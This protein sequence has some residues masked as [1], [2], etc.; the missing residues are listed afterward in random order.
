MA[1]LFPGFEYDIFISYRQK[2]NKHDGWVTGFVD[3]LK[4]ELESTFKEEISVY[5]DINPHDGLLETHDVDASLKEKLKCIIFIPV[6]SRTYCDPKAFAWEHEFLA[7]IEQASKDRFGLKIK[8]PNG[9][10][11]SRVLPVRIHDLDSADIRLCESALGGVI[12]GVDFVYKEPGVNRPL[13][14]DDDDKKNLNGTKYK[15][16]INKTANA[17]KEIISGL[18]SEPDSPSKDKVKQLESW[19]KETIG[20]HKRKVGKKIF[21][22]RSIK[23]L[24]LIFVLILFVFGANAVYKLI[25]LEETSKT[26]AV[27]FSPDI[28]ND[29][30]LAGIRDTYT[31]AVHIKL[32]AVKSLNITPRSALFQYRD[33][34][35]SLNKTLK[36]LGVNYYLYG[37][38][39]RSGN[40]IITGIELTSLKANKQLWFKSYVWGEKPVSTISAEIVQTIVSRLHA[41][42][43]PEE[44]NQIETEPT[45]NAEANQN[46]TMA[47]AMSYNAWC[48][49]IMANKY[50]KSISY[51][52]AIQSYD[53]AIEEDS[54]FAQAYAK[55]A[56]ARSFG[57]YIGQLDSTQIEKCLEDIAKASEINKDLPDIQMALGFYYYYC[58]KELDKALEFFNI[59]Y[60][61]DPKDYQ[62]L[63]YMAM[64]YRRRGEWGKSKNLI[65]KLLTLDLQDALIFT[66]IGL[67]YTYFHNYDSALLFHQKAINAMPAWRSPYNNK[68]ETLILK[69]GN[70]SEAR[71]LLET[72][73]Q[74]TGINFTE[75]K[76]LLD[77]YDRK[78]DDALKK[79]EKS[80]PADYK[81]AGNKQLFLAEI[82]EFKYNLKNA[83]L[84]YDSALV[85]L[86]R[87]IAI[88]KDDTQIHSLIGIAINT[89]NK[90]NAIAEGKKAIDLIKYDNFDKSDMILN[91]AK[92]YTMI[93][94]YDLAISTIDYLLQFPSCISIKLLKLD[95]VW[96]PLYDKPD[97]QSLLRKY[98]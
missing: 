84:Y 68:I 82:Y 79:A 46:Y 26:I 51:N 19:G 76:I 91:L 57:Y 33:T 45:R 8:L 92:I 48:S 12:R 54:L 4:G 94:E 2:D 34:E 5:F 81:Y 93:G 95:P 65:K 18:K 50:H 16:Q 62:P 23:W 78:Y 15:N 97:F 74:K 64:V 11:A 28:K 63:F 21:G 3:Q 36:D 14:T 10:V 42:L 30:E 49:Y 7:F 98:L 90:E 13:T 31:E 27:F 32:G 37:S 47:N 77:I 85:S 1:S 60:E 72:A 17:I 56:I 87:T 80:Q 52:S 83:R 61:K 55:R 6:I 71:V 29:N 22:P 35:N 96:E 59:A 69:N 70:T 53:K 39:R 41:K 38:I 88:N 25:K 66:N 58:K 9:N 24:I 89:G 86:N 40:Q 73:I 43:L 75:L 44:L 20:K 67:T